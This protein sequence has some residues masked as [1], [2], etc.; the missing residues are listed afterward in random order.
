MLLKPAISF[1]FYLFVP[2]LQIHGGRRQSWKDKSLQHHLSQMT[3]INT[4]EQM[5][6]LAFMCAVE[7]K[8]AFRF[9]GTL[10]CIEMTV[11]RYKTP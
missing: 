6:S 2:P 9:I 5:F 1:F 8:T 4:L 11:F 7:V 3:N 10:R